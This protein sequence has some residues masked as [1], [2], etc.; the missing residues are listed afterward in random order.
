MTPRADSAAFRARLAWAVYDWASNGFATVIASFVFSAYFIRAVAED[1]ATGTSQWGTAMAVSGLAVALLA[2]LAGALA[3]RGG[4]VKP[5]LAGATIGCIAA[6]AALWWVEPG[7]EHILLAL[8]LVGLGNLGF[9]LATAFYNSMLPRLVPRQQI[10]RMSGRAWSA[11]YAG[12]LACLLVA[13]LVFVQAD[14]PPF[15]LDAGQAENVRIVGPFV[16]LWFALFAIPLF[17]LTPDR[18]RLDHAGLPAAPGLSHQ[19]REVWRLLRGQPDLVRF[20]AAR[21]LYVDGLATMFIFGGLFAAGTFD[22]GIEEVLT[23]GIALN[24][25]AG[26]GAYIG[27]W[28]DDRI[29]ARRTILLSLAGLSALALPLTVAEGKH[30]FWILGLPLGLFMGP[31]QAASRSL[32]ARLAPR[33]MES[34]LFGLFAASGKLTAFTGPALVAWVTAATGSQRYG[35]AVIVGLLVAGGLLLSRVREPGPAASPALGAGAHGRR[36]PVDGGS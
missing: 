9:E 3:D 12:G 34:R 21:L 14:P 13:L 22:M 8:L 17:V 10:G 11:G 23:F 24:I 27:G 16:A 30:W 35:I 7:P 19:L 28:V 18:A 25:A 36:R 2:P 29:G 20:L 26:A 6:T 31:A 33:D 1:V 32:M 4:P 5:W 15:G